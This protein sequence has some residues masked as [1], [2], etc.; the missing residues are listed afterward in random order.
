[1]TRN[2]ALTMF[3]AKAPEPVWPVIS[4]SCRAAGRITCLAGSLTRKMPP[5]E[6]WMK[7]FAGA[8]GDGD[9]TIARTC[10]G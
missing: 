10:T 4:M 3:G 2:V 1:M 9:V 6:S 8:A 5:V 7:A